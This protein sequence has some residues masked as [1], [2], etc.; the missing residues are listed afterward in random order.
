MS[1]QNQPCL[2]LDQLVTYN[3]THLQPGEKTKIEFHLKECE[4]CRTALEGLNQESDT[5]RTKITI[6]QIEQ[7]IFASI[8]SKP[9]INWQLLLAAASVLA[10]VLYTGYQK[11]IERP[12]EYYSNK[13]GDNFRTLSYLE[14]QIND[15]FRTND[16]S[17]IVTNPIGLTIFDEQLTFTWEKNSERIVR[18]SILNNNGNV[19]F[20]KDL[21]ENIFFFMDN[22]APGLYYWSLEAGFNTIHIG[23]ILVLPTDD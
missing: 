5:K 19:V 15:N 8:K 6:Q 9:K 3:K 10:F 7:K 13:Y 22:L 18:L 2:T 20:D 21:K 17:L 23:R 4:F 16:N 12:I 14:S 11:T 1:N